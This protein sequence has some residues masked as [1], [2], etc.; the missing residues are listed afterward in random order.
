VTIPE[1]G[2][3]LASQMSRREIK[4][5]LKI[6]H[7]IEKI[8]RSHSQMTCYEQLA[9]KDLGTQLKNLIVKQNDLLKLL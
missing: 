9:N 6:S 3:T 1:K 7:L 8:K 5:N 4:A 2:A